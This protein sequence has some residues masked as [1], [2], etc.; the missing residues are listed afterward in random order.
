MGEKTLTI[1]TD[2]FRMI[3]ETV[4]LLSHCDEMIMVRQYRLLKKLL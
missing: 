3:Y 4:E 1:G 2:D